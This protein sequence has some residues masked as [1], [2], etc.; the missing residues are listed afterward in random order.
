[1]GYIYK[2]TNQINGK[3]YIGQTNYTVENR[4]RQHLTDAARE[5]ISDRPLYRAIRKYGPEAFTVECIEECPRDQLDDR[6]IYWIDQYQSY[7]Y[8][9]NATPGG[10]GRG[11]NTGHVIGYTDWERDIIQKYYIDEGP[12]RCK[13]RIKD[14]WTNRGE[15]APEHSIASIRSMANR[16]GLIVRTRSLWTPEE[17]E[18]L[19][20]YYPIDGVK[21]YKRLPGHSQASCCSQWHKLGGNLLQDYIWTDSELEVLRRY[22]PTLGPS[23]I[24]Q[25]IDRPIPSIV[26]KACQLKIHFVGNDESRWTSE[27]LDIIVTYYPLEGCHG[28]A[29]RL[30]H[31]T[32]AAIRTR[33]Q[34][35][36]HQGQL[37]PCCQKRRWTAEEDEILKKY[38]PVEVGD[39]IARLPGRSRASVY[40]RVQRLGI[41][42][43]D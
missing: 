27:E 39:V 18:I 36:Q 6:E 31:R 34:I 13:Q 16:M 5:D 3:V 43:P 25:Y 2:V 9:Y 11:S 12:K 14:E 35:L 37:G 41:V 30:P 7:Q 21:V 26:H 24:R 29:T 28:V 38:Y 23:G 32:P 19:R 20:Q 22:Y 17:L 10:A 4:W 33:I 42:V 8:G 15:E 40:M 1:M